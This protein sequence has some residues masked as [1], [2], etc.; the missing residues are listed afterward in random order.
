MPHTTEE[1]VR[2][3]ITGLLHPEFG[4]IYDPPDG[5]AYVA[6]Q[7]GLAEGE[8]RSFH[9]EKKTMAENENTKA[10]DSVI[11]TSAPDGES[12]TVSNNPDYVPGTY[13]HQ[14]TPMTKNDAIVMGVVG[15]VVAGFVGTIAWFGY[16]DEQKRA[17]ESRARMAEAKKKREEL[18]A[19]FEEQRLSGHVVIETA[20]RT[21]MAIPADAY[22]KSEVRK[23]RA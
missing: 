17:E 23:R 10:D 9:K 5:E 14:P 21:Y 22:A 16:K 4:S 1:I 20:D 11:I 18:E 15:V 7:R 13:T 12:F 8:A 6:Y 3:V 19:W 2:D